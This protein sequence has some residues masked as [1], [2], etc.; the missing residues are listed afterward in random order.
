MRLWDIKHTE[1]GDHYVYFDKHDRSRAKIYLV[2][3]NE[4]WPSEMFMRPELD[5]RLMGDNE[6]PQIPVK[7]WKRLLNIN[8]GSQYNRF[9][10][11]Y[12]KLEKPDGSST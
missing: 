12:I 11:H 3:C 10:E 2:F 9:D 8:I 1:T 4:L 5:I 7:C 6:I